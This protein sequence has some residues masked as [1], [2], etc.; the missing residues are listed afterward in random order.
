MAT[1][2]DDSKQWLQ[3]CDYP[4]Q[5][6]FYQ[7]LEWL[8]WTDILISESDL[9]AALVSKI[10]AI[11]AGSRP[12]RKVVPANTTIDMLNEFKLVGIAIKNPS[13][14]DL[15]LHLSFPSFVPPAPGVPWLEILLPANSTTDTTINQTFWADTSISCNEQT[16]VNYTATPLIFLIDR[17]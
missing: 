10:N 8:R 9:D 12:E 3:T 2:I 6:Q 4:T 16:G 14:F 11:H 15:V 5:A 13:A 1:H 17:K 7:I